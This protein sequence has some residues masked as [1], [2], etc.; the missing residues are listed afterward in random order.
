MGHH[1]A[2]GGE[3]S[4]IDNRRGEKPMSVPDFQSLMLPALKSLEEGA[5]MRISEVRERVA[6]TEGLTPEDLRE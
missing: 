1:I 4:A 5:E 3:N 2:E 6:I